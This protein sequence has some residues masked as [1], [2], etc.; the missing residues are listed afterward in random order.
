MA[1]P[2]PGVT[3]QSLAVTFLLTLRV[4]SRYNERS[5]HNGEASWSSFQVRFRSLHPTQKALSSK[6]LG[7]LV[8]GGVLAGAGFLGLSAA[9]S[10]AA[11]ASGGPFSSSSQTTPFGNHA[12]AFGILGF[13][14]SNAGEG[15]FLT[16][17]NHNSAH[18][19]AIL[20]L[21]EANAGNGL[22]L[23]SNNHNHA[24]AFALLGVAEANVG[25][26]LI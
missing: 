11:T 26:G 9:P 1:S 8:G 19:G 25:N 7:L 3:I 14:E 21:A 22:F 18:S 15:L 24:D 5:I 20:G 16:S 6:K 10:F 12:S 23:T 13:A 17:N 4:L 2:T